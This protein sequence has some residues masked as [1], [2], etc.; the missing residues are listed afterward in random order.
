MNAASIAKL[1]QRDEHGVP[2][3]DRRADE[4]LAA[5]NERLFEQFSE[6]DGL[7][8]ITVVHTAETSGEEQPEEA[9]WSQL[10]ER[11]GL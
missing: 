10:R 5:R 8:A 7:P 2:L 11:L 6:V 4:A 1:M 3:W 9:L